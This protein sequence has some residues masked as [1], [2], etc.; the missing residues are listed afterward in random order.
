MTRCKSCGDNWNVRATLKRYTTSA[1]GMACPYC[2]E[3]QYL[4]QK[5]RERSMFITLLIPLPI[6]IQAFFDVHLEGMIVL[7]VSAFLLVIMFHLFALEVEAEEEDWR[8]RFYY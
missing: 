2:G 5:Y 3:T 8:N 1:P 7:F 4:S 6:L